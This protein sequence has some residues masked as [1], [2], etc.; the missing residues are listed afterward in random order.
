MKKLR[1]RVG[2]STLDVSEVGEEPG[3]GAVAEQPVIFADPFNSAEMLERKWQCT[4]CLH[5]TLYKQG[6]NRG[7]GGDAVDS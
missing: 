6:P 4:Q 7:A 5:K 3:F 1:F 2:L